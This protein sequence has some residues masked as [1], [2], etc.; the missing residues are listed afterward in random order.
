MSRKLP[1]V[2]IGSGVSGKG[3]RSHRTFRPKRGSSIPTW[4]EEEKEEGE[5]RWRRRKRRRNRRRKKR[6][7]RKRKRRSPKNK[8]LSQY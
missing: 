8:N 3:A 7:R 4:E 5:K 6:R 2:K 1:K